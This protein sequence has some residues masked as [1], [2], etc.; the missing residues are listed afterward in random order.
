MVF[1]THY[2]GHLLSLLMQDNGLRAPLLGSAVVA[3]AA[4]AAVAAWQRSR[5]SSRSFQPLGFSLLIG[6]MLCIALW[7]DYEHTWSTLHLLIAYGGTP[8]VICGGIGA[9]LSIRHIGKPSIVHQVLLVVTLI[10]FVQV[11]V[12]PHATPVAIWAIR[13]GVTFVLPAMCLGLA[14]LA[15]WVGK[16]WHWA[17]GVALLG[18]TLAA[19]FLAARHLWEQPYYRGSLRHIEAVAAFLPPGSEILC[20][21]QLVGSGFASSIWMLYDAPAYFF[22]P[23]DTMRISEF[24]QALRGTPLYWMSNGKSRPPQGAGI[25]TV[26]VAFY[27]FALTTPELDVGP[28]STTSTTWDYTVA[29]Y[30]LRTRDEKTNAPASSVGKDALAGAGS[31]REEY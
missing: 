10:A 7:S 13:R 9:L 31:E 3:A 6:W 12:E 16:R 18:A 19:E 20:D 25:E 28:A 17:A 1:R 14:F 29:L 24:V 21:S 5:G 4:G 30:I 23:E 15:H 22:A 8:I 27:E 26:P 2:Y 11:M